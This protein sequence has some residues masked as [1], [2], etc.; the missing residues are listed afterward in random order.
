MRGKITTWLAWTWS[1]LISAGVL[2]VMLTQSSSMSDDAL[3]TLGFLLWGL[4]MIAFTLV[5]AL[6]VSRQPRNTVGWLVMITPVFSI[7]DGLTSLL[8][9]FKTIPA[10]PSTLF[11]VAAWVDNVIYL[12]A[13]FT[14][15]FI[16]QLFPNGRALSPRWRWLTT[17]GLALCVAFLSLGIFAETEIPVGNFG[18]IPNPIGGLLPDSLLQAYSTAGAAL[19][20]ILIVGSL[21]SLFI[22]YRRAGQVERKQIKWLLFACSL[23]ALVLIVLVL[24]SDSGS[25]QVAEF[26]N[27]ANVIT[28][29]AI[30][31]AIAIA[32]LR[33]NLWDID[34]IIR[35]TVV[36]AILTALLALVYFAVIV[37]LQS[38]IETVSGQQSPASI[39][40]STLVIAALFAPLRRRV[41]DF[42]DRR[43]YRRRYDAEK[44]L[45]AF[46]Q[47]TRD[48]TDLE[49]LS[50]ELLRVTEETMQPE[51]VTLWLNL[52]V[53]E[54]HRPSP[55]SATG[56]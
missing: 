37:L 36:Y 51:Q 42:I 8:G 18:A 3:G 11:V 10:E 27:M 31:V 38:I 50:A 4:F 44:T 22:R 26:L 45:A 55:T 41:Q 19:F 1:G 30:P 6:I 12:P 28:F 56:S 15:L 35:K 23:F 9:S 34:V 13:L 33:Y 14:P 40:I 7:L 25:P 16:L 21:A 46:A 5:G 52:A 32:I 24:F 54:R 53:D 39:V 2:W 49:A 48:Q 29:A 17:F 20:L 43:F 47:V